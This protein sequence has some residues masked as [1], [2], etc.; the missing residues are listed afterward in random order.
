MAVAPVARRR[1]VASE[2]YED[3]LAYASGQ[4]LHGLACEVNLRPPNPASLRFHERFG[5]EPVA[6]L[7]TADGRVVSLQRFDPGRALT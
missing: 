5:F 3:A 4:G 7:D 2:L 6:T 1:R